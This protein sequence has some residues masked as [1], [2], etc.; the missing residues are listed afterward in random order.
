MQPAFISQETIWVLYLIQGE[1]KYQKESL[2]PEAERILTA[3]ATSPM[4][5]NPHCIVSSKNPERTLEKLLS[6]WASSPLWN[7]R[8]VRP[9][10]NLNYH[11]A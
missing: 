10:R 3:V 4:V 6:G 8:N 2:T 7:W 1:P 9:R 11:V 5:V